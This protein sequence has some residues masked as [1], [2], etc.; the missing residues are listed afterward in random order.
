MLT[1]FSFSIIVYEAIPEEGIFI[2]LLIILMAL[3]R[4]QIELVEETVK[5]AMAAQKENLKADLDRL[6]RDHR[7]SADRAVTAAV[8]ASL[9]E[10]VPV[11]SGG[12]LPFFHG[13]VDES[14]DEWIKRYRRLALANGWSDDKKKEVL[15]WYLRGY[16]E[17][18]YDALTQ[19]ELLTFESIVEALRGVFKLS[20]MPDLKS[21]ELHVRVQG[22][23]ESVAEFSQAIRSLTKQGYPEMSTAEQAKLM[24]RFFINGLRPTIRQFVTLSNPADI[25]TAETSARG[26]E[27]QEFYNFGANTYLARPR[28]KN[29]YGTVNHVAATPSTGGF[30]ED[31]NIVEVFLAQQQEINSQMQN[32]SNQIREMK[33]SETKDRQNFGNSTRSGANPP[34]SQ[35]GQN[36]GSGAVCYHC[37]RTGHLRAQCFRWKNAQNRQ[38]GIPNSNNRRPPPSN[39]QQSKGKPMQRG[40][41]NPTTAPAVSFARRNAGSSPQLRSYCVDMERSP[42]DIESLVQEN[43]QLKAHVRELAMSP[44]DGLVGS[45]EYTDNRNLASENKGTPSQPTRYVSG[46]GKRV[47]RSYHD[48]C[49]MCTLMI[50][51]LMSALTSGV[52]SQ[53]IDDSA[54]LYAV[55]RNF[56]ICGNS[57][58][59]HAFSVPGRIQCLPPQEEGPIY[60]VNVELWIPSDQPI[61]TSAVKCQIRKQRICTRVGIFGPIGGRGITANER[62]Y[63]SVSADT[64]HTVNAT[65]QWKMQFL[66][67]VQPGM[68]VSN[69][70]LTV[71]YQYCCFDYCQEVEN[72][73]LEEGEIL[74]VNGQQ[75]AS[76][77]GNVGGC[78]ARLGECVQPDSIILWHHSYYL[79]TCPYT[80][81]SIQPA[82]IQGQHL[83][84]ESLQMALSFS[85]SRQRAP[86]C[87]QHRMQT[88]DRNNTRN[89]FVTD[90]GV[91]VGMQ[92]NEKD[93][94]MR[95][96]F[97]NVS[98]GKQLLSNFDKFD[99]LNL[100]LQFLYDK[101]V[102]MERTNFR[103]VWLEMC[104]IAERQ[105]RIIKQFMRMDATLGS[106]ILLNRDNITAQYAG[107][108]LLVWQCREVYSNRIYWNYTFD[109]RCYDMIPVVVESSVYFWVPGSRD[110]VRRAVEVDCHHHIHGIFR[111]GS[112]WQ[113]STGEVHVS[114]SPIT[115]AW[116]GLWNFTV[117][118]APS[119]LH[120]T[121]GGVEA[122]M[123]MLRSYVT[124]MFRVSS[125][126]GR[127]VNYTAEMSTDPRTLRAAIAGVGEGV[128]SIWHGLGDYMSGLGNLV[129]GI[130]TGPFQ[131]FINIVVVLLVMAIFLGVA[132][133]C[134][135]FWGNGS[136]RN[137]LHQRVR[138]QN[139]RIME[140]IRQLKL[141][142]RLPYRRQNAVSKGI[143]QES[144]RL[145][146]E[147]A[148]VPRDAP[149]RHDDRTNPPT[150]GYDVEDAMSPDDIVATLSRGIQSTCQGVGMIE[151]VCT[152]TVHAPVVEI[153]VHGLK[154]E[155]L[156]DTGSYVTLLSDSLY[157][158]LQTIGEPALLPIELPTG[159]ARSV[160]NHELQFLGKLPVLIK[161]GRTKLTHEVHILERS[162]RKFILGIDFLQ[163]FGTMRIDTRRQRVH[164]GRI[165]VP[166]L[167]GE[168]FSRTTKQ[169]A[170]GVQRVPEVAKGKSAVQ[171]LENI[172]IPANSALLVDA[173]IEHRLNADNLIFE[174]HRQLQIKY[175][176][177][178]PNSIV[179]EGEKD[180]IPVLFINSMNAP[181]HLYKGMQVGHV[182][183]LPG[184][185]D[186]D[187]EI[188][189][190][191]A[192]IG[193]CARDNSTHALHS[194]DLSKSELEEEEKK[195]LT[196]LLWRYKDVFSH[197]DDDLGRTNVAKHSIIT[198]TNEPVKQR[199]YRVPY[200]QRT[201]I[202]EHVNDL[203]KRKLIEPSNSPYS[204]PVLIVKKKDGSDRFCIDYRKLNRITKQDVFPLPHIDDILLSLGKSKYFTVLD[205][206]SGYWQVELD[207]DAKEKSAFCTYNGLYQWNVMP[208]GLTAAPSTYQRLM[209]IALSGL[210]WKFAF[211]FIDDLI[212]ADAEFQTHLLHLTQI[213]ER[214]RAANI[215][216]KLRKC[217]FAKASVN[218]LGHTV[219]RDGVHVD[220]S[221]VEKLQNMPVPATPT[222]VKSFLG[223]AQFYGRFVPDFA[224]I[225]HPLHTLLKKYN[226]WSW[227]PQCQQAFELLKAKLSA[228]PVLKHPDF[229]PGKPFILCTDASDYAVGAVLAQLDED[230][231]ER[232]IAFASRTLQAS[233]RNY[234]VTD[235]EGLALVWSVK[236][237]RPYI[238]NRK[239]IVYTDHIALRWL[240]ITPQPSGRLSRWAMTL[241][242]YD[243]EI[244]FRRGNN[245]SVADCLSRLVGEANVVATVEPSSEGDKPEVLDNMIR[246]LQ[247]DDAE[248]ADLIEYLESG[249]LPT[250]ET[251]S[252]KIVTESCYYTLID[253]LLYYVNSKLTLSELLVIPQKLR[254]EILQ[255]FHDDVTAAHFGFQRTYDKIRRR[256]FWRNMY[257][258][259]KRYCKQCLSCA[260][261]KRAHESVKVPMI[262]QVVS[263][264]WETVVVDML[265]PFPIT[266]RGNKYII[267][268]FDSFTKWCEAVATPDIK[269][270]RVARHFVQDVVCRHS[271][272]HKLLSDKGTNL[273][274][275]VVKEVCEMMGTKKENS[276]AYHPQTQGL[277]ERF[278]A[279]LYDS[280]AMY[281]SQN[282]HRDW[283]NY[284][285]LCLFAYRT[286]IQS[287]T[288]YSPFFLL[289]GR[290]P[291]MPV[292]RALIPPSPYVVDQDAYVHEL[293]DLLSKA[294]VQTRQNLQ[295]SQATQ[296]A[297][298]DKS[299][300]SHTFEVGQ[301]ILLRNPV[302]PP[303]K[304]AKFV[305]K[306]S[307]PYEIITVKG[308][309]LLI[310][311]LGKPHAKM[312]EVHSNS[313]KL[314]MP[315]NYSSAKSGGNTAGTAEYNLPNNNFH[316][317][318]KLKS[319][320]QNVQFKP[321]LRGQGRGALHNYNLRPRQ[322]KFM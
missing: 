175:D 262:S 249:N 237:F 137:R 308:V 242:E 97:S 58:G 318:S 222:H 46:S 145:S 284:L 180:C 35:G 236:H 263:E 164:F 247:R 7:T 156:V 131:L 157:R 36:R 186:R 91:V 68:W 305:H 47:P 286:G 92:R 116:Q 289:Y 253:G 152:I 59:A 260:T 190:V 184:E 282:D 200:E 216:L 66:H 54:G 310:R 133:I 19:A 3:T 198:T 82:R 144:K 14:F 195:Q 124:R 115:V 322:F 313:C 165:S 88:R 130:L 201:V 250:D 18:K 185:L 306:W 189:E 231:F 311:M 267:L 276:V 181:I 132:W 53:H 51:C 111:N 172:R 163:R 26:H 149:P 315:E 294:F 194:L 212:C 127:L 154:I 288:L 199:P 230:N 309:N 117:F 105:L 273:L 129:H 243:I 176:V 138:K 13:S 235:K 226:Q 114:E 182:E 316:G 2:T 272:P 147:E 248:L 285:D 128:G 279:T 280:L 158:I 177:L 191:L 143:E 57:R 225:A 278:N 118:Q 302:V 229:T 239:I 265:G 80:F 240:M 121:W 74:T 62:S 70:T 203:L 125:Q 9:R 103:S 45:I 204:S 301:L 39:Q 139:R 269:A 136:N 50:C 162:P 281:V 202:D 12:V 30:D 29:R 208:F 101:I 20:R 174:P 16:A 93:S 297:Q 300:T 63:R 219:T 146:D 270:E 292:D 170:N 217:E 55:G 257:G 113:T 155:A 112:V 140:R 246:H 167:S 89:A 258:D 122:N 5:N 193:E 153:E 4:G 254:I 52:H 28:D 296:K 71:H 213:F 183:P 160:T 60:T 108:A 119:I 287:S 34:R 32:L 33:T 73:I 173:K 25:D 241:Q 10:A 110:L 232:P 42:T 49:M 166:C 256:Y 307:G 23:N 197:S 90:Q 17:Q 291:R 48:W 275:A 168:R 96:L 245:N 298:Y 150:W 151:S 85:K 95:F 233:E 274:S 72:F 43:E 314:Y 41:P 31:R 268:F 304:C 76:D 6:S 320:V 8:N 27:V 264:P 104:H 94:T 192:E 179:P 234:S 223:L 40:I 126:L 321:N 299:A 277:S 81:L 295:K 11:A 56:T 209:T 44:S 293:K 238:F 99:P 178:S 109:G 224:Q 171:L 206:N 87:V 228:A 207:D 266:E 312:R 77:L 98:E 259:I 161:I 148:E 134:F 65:K 210:L 303:G 205:A 196:E 211:I 24:K 244:K 100:K 107:E 169:Y 61:R 79:R 67:E 261:Q 188:A 271:C 218:F 214:L 319:K 283:D 290:E 141:E 159:S 106:R 69:N 37:G 142:G 38:S 83:V 102:E 255:A 64:C 220:M 21:A 15:P 84:V 22:P 215:K 135:K 78:D 75:I 187:Y 227:T 123:A 120:N 251:L 1:L 221:K 317:S 86:P 252:R